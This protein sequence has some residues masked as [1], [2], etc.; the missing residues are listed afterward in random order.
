MASLQE[1][2]KQQQMLAQQ[3]EDARRT[4]IAEVLAKIRAQ[5]QQYGLAVSDI[6]P[7]GGR[8]RGKALGKVAPKY[9]DPS[10]GKTWTG[11]GKAPKWIDGM[12]RDQF[13]I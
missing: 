8:R 4:E 6:F 11:R 1:L 13:M 3:I 7:G 10:S 2:L 9:R 12:N 5:V